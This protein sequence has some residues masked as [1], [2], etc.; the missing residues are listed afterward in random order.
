MIFPYSY[1]LLLSHSSC[2]THSYHL[3]LTGGARGDTQENT[4]GDKESVAF[5][6]KDKDRQTDS[7]ASLDGRVEEKGKSWRYE[8]G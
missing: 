3:A 2:F 7:T 5:T 1:R 4:T 8:S 6:V